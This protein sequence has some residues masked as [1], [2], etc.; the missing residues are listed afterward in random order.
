M[1]EFAAP[2]AKDGLPK[3]ATKATSSVLDRFER[4]TTGQGTVRAGREFT[5]L[6]L[7]EDID[8]IIKS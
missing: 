2:L 6:L 1:L 3:L 5:L 4:K 8:D 7:N